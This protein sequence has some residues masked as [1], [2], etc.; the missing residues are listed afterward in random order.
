M[1]EE[2]QIAGL[3][4]YCTT[5][6]LIASAGI[7]PL[8]RY[9]NILPTTRTRVPLKQIGND[10]TTTFVNANYVPDYSMLNQKAYV[11]CQGYGSH[12]S[13][14]WVTDIPSSVFLLSAISVRLIYSRKD[15]QSVKIESADENSLTHV[16]AANY[17]VS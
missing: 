17:I 2:D 8:V 13:S 14:V 4:V 10:K 3:D 11:A 9:V 16:V 7:R 6:T 15:F 5:G 12:F 1:C